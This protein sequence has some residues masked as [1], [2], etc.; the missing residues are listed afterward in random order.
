MT[1]MWPYLRLRERELAERRHA[2]DESFL[3]KFFQ[4][5]NPISPWLWASPDHDKQ[6]VIA[7]R[8][9]TTV[10]SRWFSSTTKNRFILTR[11]WFSLSLGSDH[12]DSQSWK[13]VNAQEIAKGEIWS[14]SCQSPSSTLETFYVLE[15][16]CE[17]IGRSPAVSKQNAIGSHDNPSLPV[18]V[19]WSEYISQRLLPRSAHDS[20][21]PFLF[22]QIKWTNHEEFD[23]G[24]SRHW[25]RR[26]ASEGDAGIAKRI[27]AERYV[28]ACVVGN[29]S[30]YPSFFKA[31]SL[32]LFHLQHQRQVDDDAAD[33]TRICR[34]ALTAASRHS[35]VTD[36]QSVPPIVC[37]SPLYRVIL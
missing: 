16:T 27:V 1:D 5:G 2:Y 32:N 9:V 30:T 34:V 3:P 4:S 14:V 6:I 7:L 31:L 8:F 33:D 11:L 36:S 25:L 24:V 29:R 15:S 13:V 22:Q 28:L 21:P 23:K 19:D 12:Q 17:V 20:P 10:T 26:I 35:K 37:S 18:R